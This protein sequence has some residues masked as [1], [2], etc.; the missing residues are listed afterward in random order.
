MITLFEL[1]GMIANVAIEN[2]EHNT[3]VGYIQSLID[4]YGLAW[5]DADKAL[6]FLYGRRK[7]LEICR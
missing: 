3:Q 1:R 4:K 7:E 6:D 5:V 2:S